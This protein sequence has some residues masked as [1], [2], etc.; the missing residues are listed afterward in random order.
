MDWS[1]T[2][3]ELELTV[4]VCEGSSM[5]I[6]MLGHTAQEIVEQMDN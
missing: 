1:N 3:A 4:N 6:A 5:N 2:Q